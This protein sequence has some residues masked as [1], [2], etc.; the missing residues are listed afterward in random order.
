MKPDIVVEPKPRTVVQAESSAAGKPGEQAAAVSDPAKKEDTESPEGKKIDLKDRE[1]EFMK[2]DVQL[3]KAIELLKT[4]KVF[5]D[6]RP[7]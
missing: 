6:L 4:W 2:K 7:L 3:Q 1:A 5:K